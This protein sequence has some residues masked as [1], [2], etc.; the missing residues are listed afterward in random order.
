VGS[1]LAAELM[2]VVSPSGVGLASA[3]PMLLP[4]CCSGLPLMKRSLR[5]TL[6]Q[7]VL[8]E[9]VIRATRRAAAA[10]DQ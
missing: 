7:V 8:R 10:R 6:L 4:T 9:A 2:A 3:P 5:K 1:W